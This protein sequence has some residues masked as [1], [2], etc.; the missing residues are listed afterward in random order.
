MRKRTKLQYKPVARVYAAVLIVLI[1]AFTLATVQAS[2]QAVMEWERYLFMKAYS[3]PLE[4]FP[5]MLVVSQLGSS[6]MIL[7]SSAIA[8]MRRKYA[9]GAM[10]LLT[11]GLA[12]VLTASVKWFVQRPRP[13]ELVAG[14]EQRDV[15]TIGSGYPSMYAAVSMVLALILW[16]YAPKRYRGVVIAGAAAVGISRLYLGANLPLDLIGGWLIGAA[17][18]SVVRLSDL[19]AE[20]PARRR[21]AA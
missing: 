10:I 11:G 4:L 1:A 16:K 13:L 2:R 21:K 3:L 18:W 5:V 9:V 17:V 7:V 8:S 15:L 6:W 12:Y 14:I 19:L 20:R